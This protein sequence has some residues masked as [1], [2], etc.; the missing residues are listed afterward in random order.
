M[1]A[2]TDTEDVNLL[3]QQPMGLFSLIIKSSSEKLA[4]T[5]EQV[6]LTRGWFELKRLDNACL[7][8]KFKSTQR[9]K[10][11]HYSKLPIS[12]YPPLRVV[13]LYDN[14]GELPELI[15]LSQHQ[16]VSPGSIGIAQDRS[17]GDYINGMVE[18]HP[19]HF[20]KRGGMDSSETLIDM[21]VKG[22]V[23]GIIEYSGEVEAYI[24]RHNMDVKV[25]SI[26]IKHV[27]EPDYGYMVCSKS[28]TGLALIEAM[29][30]I[31]QQT[32][33]QQ[34]YIETHNAFFTEEERQLLA[35]ELEKIFN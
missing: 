15:D 22:R 13:T 5:Q 10:L 19:E 30:E 21:L 32:N 34:Q 11:G 7:Y 31:M 28:A 18:Q 8:N 9:E 24:D 20:F 33:F 1:F 23:Q 12:V 6:S 2:E 4:F 35:P 3:E 29:D 17:Y 27:T 14:P 25:H 26:P 16:A